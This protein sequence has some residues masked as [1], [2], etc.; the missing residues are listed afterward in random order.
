M[1]VVNSPGDFEDNRFWTDAEY[2][3]RAWQ[4][5]RRSSLFGIQQPERSGWEWWDK[6]ADSFTNRTKG[7]AEFQRQQEVIKLLDQCHFLDPEIE[8]L[9][10]GCGPGNY[11]LQLARRVKKVVALDPSPRMLDILQQRAAEEGI[12]N[13]ETIRLTWEEVDLG[14]LS[15]KG[16]FGLVLA[17][18]TPGINDGE[19]LKKMVAASNHGCYYSGFACCDEP[20]Q[21]ELW[22][23]LFQREMPPI[24][25]DIF[26]AF[27]LLYAWGYCPSLNLKRRE[28][29]REMTFE[30]AVTRLALAMAPYLEI[31]EQI[32]NEII[33]VVEETSEEGIFYQERLIIEGNMTWDV[34]S[35]QRVK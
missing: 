35:E 34:N 21:N 15:W 23:R 33:K 22:Q 26:Y 20:A 13:I 5:E 11:A 25:A 4:R 6:R 1:R 32:K 30:E 27:H 29:R 12:T 10:I 18:M 2:W 24:P 16:R 7:E 28:S 8:V 9:D 14:E 31:T 3:E 17:A 19:T